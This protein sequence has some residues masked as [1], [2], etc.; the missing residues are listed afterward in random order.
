MLR[1]FSVLILWFS[2]SSFSFADPVEI[3]FNLGSYGFRSS[4]GFDSFQLGMQLDL[5][6][7]YFK[8]DKIPL[9]LSISPFNANF[10]GLIG[11]SVNSIYF[12]NIKL[13]YQFPLFS[14]SE[15]WLCPEVSSHFL[16]INGISNETE[17]G[18]RIY[19]RGSLKG[20]MFDKIEVD[21][22]KPFQLNYFSFWSG[23]RYREG[24]LS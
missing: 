15:I 19:S 9:A 16:N 22:Q 6:E 12:A 14:N 11:K 5:I 17:L 2:A 7:T 10:G 21:I 24:K 3:D 8:I 20:K 1:I 18:I 23:V 13:L 4:T